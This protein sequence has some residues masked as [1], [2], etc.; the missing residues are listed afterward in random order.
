MIGNPLFQSDL[1]FNKTLGLILYQDAFE[2]ANPLGSGKKKHKIL[3]V[4]LN[5]ADIA[6]HYRSSVEQMQLVLLC[7]EQDFKY[8][9]QEKVFSALITDLEEI[10]ITTIDGHVKG[11]LCA[12]AGDNLG[13]HS[14]G[15]FVENFRS[16]YFCRF[17]GIDHEIFVSMPL[18]K[19]SPR[20]TESY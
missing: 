8:F 3:A 10:G 18:S 20:T 13:S 6:P 1:C 19:S 7:R 5:F 16:S 17:C 15:G 2:V 12:I 9:G 4:Y 14:I 11:T